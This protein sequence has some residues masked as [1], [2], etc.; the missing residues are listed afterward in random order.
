VCQG[1]EDVSWHA[2]AEVAHDLKAVIIKV[3][4]FHAL[5]VCPVVCGEH[6]AAAPCQAPS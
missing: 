6:A 5:R 3:R 1:A 4:E 2:E